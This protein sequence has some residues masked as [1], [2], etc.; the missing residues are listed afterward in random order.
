RSR[1]PKARRKTANARGEDL[2][3]FRITSGLAGLKRGWRRLSAKLTWC[4]PD[5]LSKSGV[6]GGLRIESHVVGDGKN[7]PASLGQEPL[8]FVDSVT[9]D[10]REE[11]FF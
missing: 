9:I 10:Q 1:L 7:V 3:R 6:E 2:A 4:H 5:M 8:G 11:V